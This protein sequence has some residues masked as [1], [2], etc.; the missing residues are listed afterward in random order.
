MAKIKT[1]RAL[2]FAAVLVYSIGV[3]LYS[4]SVRVEAYEEGFAKGVEEMKKA[5]ETKQD[6]EDML[7]RRDENA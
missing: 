2:E 5:Y 6:C 4:S 1:L 3:G 7:K